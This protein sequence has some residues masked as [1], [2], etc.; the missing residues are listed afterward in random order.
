MDGVV[1]MGVGIS[2]GRRIREGAPGGGGMG[3][4]VRVKV[5]VRVLMLVLVL[6]LAS[7]S[8]GR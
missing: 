5:L 3:M 2:G 6:V 8:T 4:G 1:V 7:W